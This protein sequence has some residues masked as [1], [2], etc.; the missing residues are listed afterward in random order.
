MVAVVVVVVVAVVVVVVVVV[1]VIVVVAVQ[2]VVVVAVTVTGMALPP[3][4]FSESPFALADL[5]S[6]IGSLIWQAQ[7]GPSSFFHPS[8]EL[9]IN[10]LSLPL[11]LL[12]RLLHDG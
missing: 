1:V 5:L 3:R 9:H 8:V 10:P 2:E 7:F 11:D 6:Q 4:Y 12:H